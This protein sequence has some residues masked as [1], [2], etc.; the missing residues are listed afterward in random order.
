M[1]LPEQD[2]GAIAF[3]EKLLTLLDEGSFTATYKYAVLLGLMDLCLEQSTRTGAAPSSVTT[4]QLARKVLEMYWPH[5]RA[6]SGTE[7]RVLMQNQPYKKRGGNQAAIV[8]AIQRFRARYAPD[9]SATLA[10]ARRARPERFETLLRE[11]EWKL[12]EMPLPRLQTIGDQEVAFIYRINWDR[13][14]TRRQLADESFFDNAIRFVGDASDHLVRLA[15]LLRPLIQ[16]QWAAMVARFNQDLVQDVELEDFLF[17]VD[18]RRLAPVRP[19]LNELQ[20]GGCFYCAGRLPRGKGQV[21]HFVPWAR[22]PNDAIENLVLAHARCNL[23]KRD[24]LASAPHVERWAERNDAQASAL[25][26]IAD[27]AAWERDPGR[28]LGVA[29]SIYLRLPSDIRLWDGVKSFAKPDRRTLRRV[30]A[31]VG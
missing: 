12:V 10:S 6:F 13:S 26:Q 21:D 17:G 19:G 3:A 20:S 11:V 27:D 24:H 2:R 23:D 8:T 4:R 18:R 28:T 9:P 7:G 5:T 30:L 16:R 14:I 22:Y 15:G 25:V 29:R 1:S 31:R